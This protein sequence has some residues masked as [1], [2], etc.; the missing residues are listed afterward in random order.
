MGHRVVQLARQQDPLLRLHLL[1]PSLPGAVLGTLGPAQG[2]GGHQDSDPADGV[3]HPGPVEQER[4]G[5]RD[6]DDRQTRHRLAPGAPPEQGVGEHEEVDHRV[7]V[8]R[9]C[10]GCD[11]ADVHDRDHAEGGRDHCER[12][13][14]SPQQQRRQSDR[15]RHR[16]PRERQ[17]L[18]QDTLQHPGDRH[19]RQ[20]RPVPPHPNRRGRR[21]G[22]LQQGPQWV[23][24]PLSVGKQRGQGT[25][26]K[27]DPAPSRRHDRLGASR[28]M[29]GDHERR[30]GGAW[31]CAPGAGRHRRPP[32]PAHSNA[33]A[34]SPPDVRGSSSG[35][36][37]R[38][39]SW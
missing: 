8:E 37:W 10:V 23:A 6:Q 16:Q 31:S 11:Q 25:G 2:K 38:S 39:A 9:R 18:T 4:I 30:H 21:P 19:D 5:G 1:Q 28:P 35:A 20:Q 13:G 7:H 26:R 27:S 36:G 12:V 33:S 34:A 15:Q 22:L 24:H 32:C 29:P 3:A 14:T 17:V